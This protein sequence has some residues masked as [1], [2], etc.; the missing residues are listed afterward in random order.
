[1]HLQLVEIVSGNST[2]NAFMFK[3]LIERFAFRFVPEQYILISE[4]KLNSS[5]LLFCSLCMYQWPTS[6]RPGASL[7]RSCYWVVWNQDKIGPKVTGTTDIS[8]ALCV[9]LTNTIHTG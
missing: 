5:M 4:Q 2:G 7:C 3:S 8:N 1:M 6:A 9:P